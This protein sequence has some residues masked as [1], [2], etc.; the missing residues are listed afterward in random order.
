M[1]RFCDLIRV[2]SWASMRVRS[3]VQLWGDTI[4]YKSGMSPTHGS[5]GSM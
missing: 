1:E 3:C 2:V 4:K 5:E